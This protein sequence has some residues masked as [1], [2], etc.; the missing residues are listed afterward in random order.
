[1]SFIQVH[2]CVWKV[3]FNRGQRALGWLSLKRFVWLIM[4]YKCCLSEV[5]L[6]LSWKHLSWETQVPCVT[7]VLQVFSLAIMSVRAASL[8]GHSCWGETMLCWVGKDSDKI[9][10]SLPPVA[11]GRPPRGAGDTK[12]EPGETNILRSSSDHFSGRDFCPWETCWNHS[13]K[14]LLCKPVCQRKDPTHGMDSF[15]LGWWTTLTG[16]PWAKQKGQ[17]HQSSP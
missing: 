16:M 17:N 2:K 9:W 6:P 5:P 14:V 10:P 15:P 12:Q 8:R 4:F 11:H 1:M 13:R 3:C 7:H